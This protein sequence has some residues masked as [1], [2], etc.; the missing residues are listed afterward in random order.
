MKTKKA[1]TFLHHRRPHDPTEDRVHKAC[2][3]DHVEIRHKP[4]RGNVIFAAFDDGLR[5]SDRKHIVSEDAIL[6]HPIGMS[7][8]NSIMDD[9]YCVAFGTRRGKSPV[10]IP[11]AEAV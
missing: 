11:E 9:L 7:F 2:F 6:A 8:Y 1:D 5:K 10:A 3:V 4:S